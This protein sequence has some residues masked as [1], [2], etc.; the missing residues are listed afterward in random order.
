MLNRRLELAA[1]LQEI[2]PDRFLFI[3]PGYVLVS[4]VLLALS[5]PV[6]LFFM[7]QMRR[8]PKLGAAST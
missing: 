8:K 3:S 6:S 1:R 2:H 5:I 7:Y 4:G